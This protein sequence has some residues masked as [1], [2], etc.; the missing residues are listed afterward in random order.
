[1]KYYGMKMARGKNDA[2]HDPKKRLLIRLSFLRLKFWPLPHFPP[3]IAADKKSKEMTGVT[4]NAPNSRLLRASPGHQGM[5]PPP[6][7]I[8]INPL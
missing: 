8:A 5:M 1:M 6:H 2:A 3:A 4:H 7:L